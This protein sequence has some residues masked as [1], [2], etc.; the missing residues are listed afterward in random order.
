MKP[1]FRQAK[2][3]TPTLFERDRSEA[4]DV[5]AAS[6][7]GTAPVPASLRRDH[8]GLPTLSQAE[9]VRHYTRL[10]QKNVGVDTSF[11]PLGSCTMKYNPKVN[12]LV[13]TL[14]GSA[15]VHPL[16]GDDLSQG[17]LQVIFELQEWLKEVAGMDAVTLQPAAGAQG[18]WVG[19]LMAR[20]YHEE[21][22]PG[23]RTEVIVPDNAHGTN[24]ASAAMAGYKVISIPTGP[25]GGVDLEALEAALS[26]RTAAFMITNPSTLGIFE[27]NILKIAKMV[28]DAGA[29]LY[30]DG[31]NFNAIMGITS[32]GAMGFDIVHFNL[33]KTM[34]IPHGGGGPGSGPVG[35][36]AR[37]APYLPVPVVEK[38]G[39]R[40]V[41][42][43]DA[44]RSIGKVKSFHGNFMGYIRSLVY[45]KM[46]GGDG[47]TQASQRAVLNANYMAKRLAQVPG[48]S[49][50][51]DALRKHEFVLSAAG[52]K[53]D[54]GI[55]ALDIGKRLL[56]YGYHAPTV[57]FPLIVEEAIMV[58]PTET[59]SKE[60]LDRFCDA[61][62]YVVSQ[63]DPEVVR[64]APHNTSVGR[65]DEV[66]AVKE[67]RLTFDMGQPKDSGRA[68]GDSDARNC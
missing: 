1:E 29:L 39:D 45:C 4:G 27:E 12:D 8:V 36:K 50:P 40:Y 38:R 67:A 68:T 9:V 60:T 51:H 52:A 20:A 19:L 59:E 24:P 37:L 63:E 34:T 54:R 7:Q 28:H 11:Y 31:A 25:N 3:R 66:R 61:L 56:D 15:D 2:W 26:D 32:P 21:R 48:L 17:S 18:E 65:V 42:N 23:K 46:M 53:K 5:Y 22:E 30:Y 10:S 14:P 44:P 62:A 58:E 33:H 64:G 57:Y 35:V 6:V 47:L 49:I 43:Y 41:A 16:V 13:A 55:R